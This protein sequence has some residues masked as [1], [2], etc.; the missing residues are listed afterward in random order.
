MPQFNAVIVPHLMEVASGFAK[1][2]CCTFYCFFL[3]HIGEL[4][5]SNRQSHLSLAAFNSA[6]SATTFSSS[7]LVRSL[8]SGGGGGAV[9]SA[10]AAVTAIFTACANLS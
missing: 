10:T 5:G 4:H 1:P 9:A 7:C 6:V 2:K 8:R 3:F